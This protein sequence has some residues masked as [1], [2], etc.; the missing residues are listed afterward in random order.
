MALKTGTMKAAVYQGGSLQ[1]LEVERPRPGPGE[2][3]VRVAACG[4]C[5]TDLHYLDHG[6]PTFKPPPVVLGHECSGRIEELGPGVVGWQTGQPVLLPA[7]FT[8][9]Q[10]PACRG[11][12][13]N[14]CSMMRML[15]N[16]IDGAYAEWVVA[17]A[18]ELMALPPELPLAESCII[19]DALTTPYHAVVRRGQVR[20]GDRV[21]VLG[22][23]GVGLG[24]VQ[25]ARA[26]GGFVAAV[27][28]LPEKLALAS[29]LGAVATINPEQEDNL[30]RAVSRELSGSPQVAFEAV[31]HPETLAAALAAV[32][33]GGRVVVVGY[34]EHDVSLKAS[35]VMFRELEICGSLGCRPVDYPRVIEMVRRGTLALE[36]MVSHRFAL[37][38][39][40]QGLDMLRKGQLIRGI[41]VP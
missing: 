33:P 22:C 4:L 20:P 39:I 30:S 14:I 13:E 19:A 41:V 26:A 2:V 29:R 23:G 12:R 36:P 24:L 35:R 3:L 16:H 15:G 8:C 5:H 11:G 25:M 9:G 1:V 31:G 10:C 6:V 34:C 32:E 28:R 21:L 37:S 40:H 38:D 27:D 18:R 7:V 17:S